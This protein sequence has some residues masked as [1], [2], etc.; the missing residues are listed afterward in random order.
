MVLVG[1]L[2]DGLPGQSCT[3][4]PP[5]YRTAAA[6]PGLWSHSM[7]AALMHG[8]LGTS[9]PSFF[10]QILTGHLPQARPAWAPG[11]RW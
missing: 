5:S 1:L 6:L 9:S 4:Q 2:A 7:H 11:T 3:R 8:D 10:A